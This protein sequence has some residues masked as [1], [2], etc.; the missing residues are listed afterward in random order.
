MIQK[1]TNGNIKVVIDTE[2]G[3]KIRYTKDS[4]FKP[5]FAESI[6]LTITYKC[7][8]E[9]GNHQEYLKD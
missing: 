4:V 8:G 5:E 6:D 2:N 3:T 7:D 9:L 1:Y